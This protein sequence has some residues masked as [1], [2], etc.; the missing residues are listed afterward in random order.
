[1]T[2]SGPTPAQIAAAAHAAALKSAGDHHDDDELLELEPFEAVIDAVAAAEVAVPDAAPVETAPVQ[3]AQPAQP[4]QAAEPAPR[5]RKRGR[6]VAPAGPPRHID[7]PADDSGD[8]VSGNASQ[9]APQ[10]ASADAS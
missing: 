3:P 8:D 1:V 4:V 2:H 10:A 5:R 9:G 7:E 6:V